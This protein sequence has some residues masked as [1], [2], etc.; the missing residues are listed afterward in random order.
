MNKMIRIHKNLTFLIVLT[1]IIILTQSNNITVFASNYSEN[2]LYNDQILEG[3]FED[4]NVIVVLN[5]K[6]SKINKMHNAKYFKGIEIESITDLTK[7]E[8]N[9]KSKNND[10][11]QI[12]QIHLKEKGKENVLN[13]IS[14]LENLDGVYSA[15]PNY[16]FENTVDPDDPNYIDNKLWGLNGTNGINVENAWNF[17]TGNNTIRVGIIDTGIS[18]H[19]DLNANLV[20]GRD[21]F[22]DNDITNLMILIHMV[23]MLQ[24][25][26]VQ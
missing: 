24:E 10:F 1:F 20:S 6:V 22:N 7:R 5:S 15:E 11:K 14:Y 23:P 13:A 3:D 18:N 2:L 17:T 19:V 4:D 8:Y 16:I 9:F 12:L 21:T 26:L 25:L